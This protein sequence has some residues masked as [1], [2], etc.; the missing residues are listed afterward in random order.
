[1]PTDPVLLLGDLNARIASLLPSTPQQP[2]RTSPDRLVSTRGRAL[3]DLLST[4][5]LIVLNG[6]TQQS[7][8]ATSFSHQNPLSATSVVDLA[9]VSLPALHLKTSLEIDDPLLNL[10]DHAP[11]LLSLS[12]PGLR[13][14]PPTQGP[15]V[16]RPL[17]EPGA[18]P[19]WL[20]LLRSPQYIADF[21][22]ALTKGDP[23]EE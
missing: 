3:L 12:L 20:D 6:T 13:S 21:Q 2:P 7:S 22:A 5:Q 17:W 14:G 4:H 19:A 9:L 10:S 1:M 15:P 16:P 11:L 8:R 18:H 23:T